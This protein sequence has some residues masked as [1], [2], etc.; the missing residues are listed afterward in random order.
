MAV[1][2]ERY[3]AVCRPH[4]YRQV[5]GLTNRAATYISLALLGALGVC[6]PRFLEVSP[7]THCVDFSHCRLG[8]H[9]DPV[10]V[11]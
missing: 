7:V 4:H 11:Q 9:C 6:I 5:Q 1:G 3:L 8:D 2:V 10:I